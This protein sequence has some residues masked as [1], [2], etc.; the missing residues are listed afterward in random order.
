M[1]I[2][3]VIDIEEQTKKET[4]AVSEL[5]LDD[6]RAALMKEIR[7]HILDFRSYSNSKPLNPL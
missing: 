4:P 6:Y 7:K 1:K 5:G 2:T 3:I